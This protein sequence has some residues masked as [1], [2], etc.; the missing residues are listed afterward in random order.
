MRSTPIVLAAVLAVL[1]LASVIH[2]LVTSV[3]RRRSDLALLATLGFTK[4]QL[5]STVAWQGMT[6]AFVGLLFGVPL[7]IALGRTGWNTLADDLGAVADP[8]IPVLVIAAI[9]L[10]ALIVTTAGALVPARLASRLEPAA[11]LRS[12]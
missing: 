6:V 2:A 5:S 12:E 9:A 3:R 8:V 10:G 11:V 4:R 7:G 1:A